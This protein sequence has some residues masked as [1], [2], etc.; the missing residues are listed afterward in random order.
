M[1]VNTIVSNIDSLKILSSFSNSVI[2]VASL[3]LTFTKVGIEK[4]HSEF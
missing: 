4:L 2:K 3:I 1:I